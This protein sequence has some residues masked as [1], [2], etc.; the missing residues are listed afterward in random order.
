MPVMNTFNAARD[1]I[2]GPAATSADI[3][4]F[5]ISRCRNGMF[6]TYVPADGF[7]TFATRDS[8]QPAMTATVASEASLHKEM[9]SSILGE[10]SSPRTYSGLLETVQ[11]VSLLYTSLVDQAVSFA[12]SSSL[13][14]SSKSHVSSSGSN[15]SAPAPEDLAIFRALCAV[16]SHY[17][18]NSSD[19]IYRHSVI[20]VA[21]ML[22][23][24]DS[25][26]FIRS[27]EP[28]EHESV[29]SI[30]RNMAGLADNNPFLNSKTEYISRLV[31]A[32]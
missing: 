12:S 23:N 25:C 20:A 27:M 6:T 30:L 21:D 4:D 1:L 7:G 29:V 26:A 16:A 31:V 28:K 11:S 14:S 9:K 22:T 19:W 24:F 3:Q 13:G 8:E 5:M 17:S 18:S 15:T 32:I 10:L 2:T